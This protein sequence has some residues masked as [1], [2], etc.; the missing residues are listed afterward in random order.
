LVQINKYFRPT[1]D[2]GR[3]ADIANSK[4]WLD[5]KGEQMFIVQPCLDLLEIHSLLSSLDICETSCK[6]QDYLEVSLRIPKFT[7]IRMN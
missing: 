7:L 1:L 5:Q 2:C 6:K 4:F 3:I